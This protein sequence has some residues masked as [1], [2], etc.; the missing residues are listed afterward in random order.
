MFRHF[1]KSKIHRA[2]VTGADLN[3]IGSITLCTDLMKAADLMPYEKVQVVDITNGARLETYVIPSPNGASGDICLN[4][5]AARLISKDDLVIIISYC[6]I[7]DKELASFKP[8]V[9]FVNEDNA[10]IELREEEPGFTTHLELIS[11]SK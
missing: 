3:Y 1:C 2:K 9:V 11:N 4:G 8:K 5:A 7:D 10:I 6:M